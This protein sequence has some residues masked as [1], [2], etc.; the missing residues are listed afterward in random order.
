MDYPYGSWTCACLIAN[1]WALACEMRARRS[2]G[3]SVSN[4]I[5]WCPKNRS[6]SA[7]DMG[8]VPVIGIH[9]SPKCPTATEPVV[10]TFRL[11]V[12]YIPADVRCWLP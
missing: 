10:H 1:S 6:Y 12:T 7:S 9:C 11:S 4:A 5:V 3:V 8:Q 2:S